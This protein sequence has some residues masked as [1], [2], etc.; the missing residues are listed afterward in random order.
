[1]FAITADGVEVM[2]KCGNLS[3]AEYQGCYLHALHLAYSQPKDND[4]DEPNEED[5]ATKM[6]TTERLMRVC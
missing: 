2:K 5:G 4:E 1:M 6:G 3:D